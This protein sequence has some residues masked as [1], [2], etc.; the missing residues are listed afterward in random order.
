MQTADPL[1]TPTYTLFPK[2]DYFFS[3]S[4][5][6]VSINIG[7]AYDHGYYSPNIDIT[8]VGMVG[9]GVA[10]NGVDGPQPA[11]GNQPHDPESTNT[12]PEASRVG[13]WVEETDIR[14]TM[15]AADRPARRL[16][17]GRSRDHAGPHVGAARAR[18]DGRPGEGLRRRST[19]A[20]ASSRPTR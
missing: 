18:G 12:V 10:K 6:N 14:P 13:T 3:T 4:G 2:P 15:L 5:P 17:V 1:R 7:F 16:P 20:S 9:P 19:R 11:G 8:W